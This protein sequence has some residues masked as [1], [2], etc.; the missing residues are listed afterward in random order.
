MIRTGPQYPEFFQ[1]PQSW[2]SFSNS[3][4]P[5]NPNL[6]YHGH[7]INQNHVTPKSY[8]PGCSD[9]PTPVVRPNW[10]ACIS[11]GPR[12]ISIAKRIG[13]ASATFSGT[14]TS[15]GYVVHQL[16]FKHWPAVL[17]WLAQEKL[18]P[19]TNCKSMTRTSAATA[20]TTTTI[21]LTATL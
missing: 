12:S 5:Y 11:L 3:I 14:L 4:Q 2:G 8:S 13:I 15:L 19:T 17:S 21:T 18:L 9:V 20:T 16:T 10:A 1:Q 7:V 6:P